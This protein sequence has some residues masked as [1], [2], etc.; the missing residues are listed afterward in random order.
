MPLAVPSSP[1]STKTI[2]ISVSRAVGKKERK[3]RRKREK[4]EKKEE[5]T[6]EVGWKGEGKK[7]RTIPS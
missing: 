2:A 6:Q 7:E 5:R 4:K 1:L 3:G